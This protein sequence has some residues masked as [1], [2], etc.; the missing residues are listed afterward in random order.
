MQQFAGRIAEIFDTD[1]VFTNGA[2]NVTGWRLL[3]RVICE[4]DEVGERAGQKVD[5]RMLRFRLPA[6]E[7]HARHV[8]A[9]GRAELRGFH[10]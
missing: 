6:E 10:Q 2:G 4:C 1:L 8:E 3:I 9:V 5:A 7:C